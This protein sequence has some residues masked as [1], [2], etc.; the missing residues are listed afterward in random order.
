MKV[1][2]R[3]KLIYRIIFEGLA[4]ATLEKLKEVAKELGIK[5]EEN[6]EA[7]RRQA[8]RKPVCEE[9][10]GFKGLYQERW[11]MGEMG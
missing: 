4:F 8:E 10:E 3:A 6:E 9:A 11:D 1:E 5:E 7:K 2:Q